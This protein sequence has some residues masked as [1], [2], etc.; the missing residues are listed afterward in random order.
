MFF[1][2]TCMGDV[3]EIGNEMPCSRVLELLLQILDFLFLLGF[4][5]VS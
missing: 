4:L 3:L 1:Q 2:L 5:K